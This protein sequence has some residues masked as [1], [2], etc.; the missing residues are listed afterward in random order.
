MEL[1]VAPVKTPNESLQRLVKIGE[2]NLQQNAEQ[3]QMLHTI[4]ELNTDT[5]NQLIQLT[6]LTSGAQ[7]T[8]QNA[9]INLMPRIMLSVLIASIWVYV[10]LE[11]TVYGYETLMS[12][13][14]GR[15]H[16]IGAAGAEPTLVV[17]SRFILGFS[18]SYIILTAI[19]R[20]SKFFIALSKIK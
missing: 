5:R 4:K 15:S 11:S 8:K 7:L 13:V 1:Q 14:D 2:M 9:S 6:A 20:F 18:G 16:G 12:F 19:V 17:I 10:Y 3:T